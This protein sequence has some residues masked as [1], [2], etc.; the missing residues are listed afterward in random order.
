VIDTSEAKY[1]Q[2]S[3]G[4]IECSRW[5]HRPVE[6]NV[7][8]HCHTNLNTHLTLKLRFIFPRQREG[9]WLTKQRHAVEANSSSASQ[10]TP[11]CYRTQWFVT[12]FTTARYF[13]TC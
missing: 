11:T 2:Q 7:D 12:T 8:R 5:R 10:E 3:F 9:V 4:T 13:S 6:R 1:F